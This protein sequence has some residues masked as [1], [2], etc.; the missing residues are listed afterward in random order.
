V[1]ITTK[2]T[3][4]AADG[5]RVLI[6]VHNS[7]S[8]I[9]PGKVDKIFKPFYTDK[10][11][12]TGLGLAICQTIIEEHNGTLEAHSRPDTGTEFVIELPLV[13]TA[14]DDDGRVTK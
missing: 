3:D 6:Q 11:G 1:Q 13:A 5:D 12:G 9:P 10:A 14:R 2:Q 7:G 4:A 8:Y